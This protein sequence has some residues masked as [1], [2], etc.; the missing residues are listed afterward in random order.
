M[1]GSNAHGME[2]LMAWKGTCGLI[3]AITRLSMDYSV[4]ILAADA[5]TKPD[6]CGAS[7]SGQP[8]RALL[9]A[10]SGGLR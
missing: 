3:Y 4:W 5:I 2:I 8:K 9:Q 6:S 1:G 7:F 10:G